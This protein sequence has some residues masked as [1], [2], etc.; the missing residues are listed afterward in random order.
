LKSVIET[1]RQR[2]Q[3]AVVDNEYSRVVKKIQ[4][5]YQAKNFK[6]I[7]KQKL[8]V[9]PEVAILFD[10]YKDTNFNAIQSPFCN[11]SDALETVEAY[12][13][14]LRFSIGNFTPLKIK[15]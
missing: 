12:K 2:I 1:N 11:F 5:S 13:N 4:E 10:E 6:K 8:K 14:I 3:A 7:M 15:I 9:E